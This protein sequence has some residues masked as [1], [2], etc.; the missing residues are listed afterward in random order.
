MF[1]LGGDVKNIPTCTFLASFA[2]LNAIHAKCSFPNAGVAR[3]INFDSRRLQAR[4][5]HFQGV[6]GAK[7]SATL[8]FEGKRRFKRR[9]FVIYGLFTSK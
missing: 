9:L 7:G 8:A 6:C 4:V 2:L 3:A 5:P 1:Q